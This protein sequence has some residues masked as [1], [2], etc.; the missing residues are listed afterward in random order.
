MCKKTHKMNSNR[1]KGICICNFNRYCQIFLHLCFTDLHF[2]PQRTCVP[3]A[4]QPNQYIVFLNFW[5]VDR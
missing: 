5:N 3:V 1:S 2:H 4:S